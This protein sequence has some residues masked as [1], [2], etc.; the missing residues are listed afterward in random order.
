MSAHLYEDLGR[1][2]RG[3]SVE[4]LS[5]QNAE[6]IALRYAPPD[7]PYNFAA[8]TFSQLAPDGSPVARAAGRRHRPLPGRPLLRRLLQV[9]LPMR[10]SGPCASPCP[11]AT[12]WWR[13]A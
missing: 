5:P 1:R 11:P 9:E 13:A 3:P 7:H 8:L 10:S 12:G 4:V 6:P 2:Y